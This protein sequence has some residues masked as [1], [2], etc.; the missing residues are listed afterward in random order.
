MVRLYE[1]IVALRPDWHDPD[2]AKGV[3]KVVM[4]GST[5][6]PAG[7][8]PHVYT[9]E[10]RKDL[11][12]RAKNPDDPL[13]LVIVRDMW[14]TGF[15]APSMHT[16]YLDKTMQGAG[17][18]QAIARVNRTFRDKPGGV[19]RR[20]H[21]GVLQSAEGAHRILADRPRSGGGA[22]RGH[23]GCAAGE[24]RHHHRAAAWLRLRLLPAPG[25]GRAAHP[26]RGRRGLR[27]E[28]PRPHRTVRRQVLALAKAY[29]LC[30]ARDEAVA[31][32]DD[33]R[34]FIDVR[35]AILKIQNPDAGRGGSGGV[36]IDTA[37]AQLVNEAVTADEVVDIYKLAG[38]ETPE[39]S[40][41]SDEFLDSLTDKEKPNLQMGPLRRLL[42]DEIKTVR[43]TNIVQARRFSEQLEEAINRYTNRSLT[44]AEVIAE[45]VKLAK[46]M[47]DDQKRHQ[48]LGLASTRSPSTT[49][50]CK[51]I[52][53]VLEMG[54][55]TLK[56]I[57][58]ELVERSVPA[59]PSTEPQR[60]RSGHNAD[61][62]P[63]AA[64]Q[65]RLPARPGG[66]WRSSWCCNKRSFSPAADRSKGGLFLAAGLPGVVALNAAA[67]R[68][69][70]DDPGHGFNYAM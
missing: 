45:L 34:L 49:P 47:R 12:L 61:Q 17:L 58:H 63:P 62:D 41:L 38:V 32:R 7:L 42:N 60:E 50:S 44:T 39:L 13:E 29:A 11:K 3:I 67:G 16:M 2:P 1:K 8:Q 40:I 46:E 43:R 18:M 22:D 35:S 51:T 24:A 33:V 55:A 52:A 69:C 20:L 70:C 36:E 66:Q 15:D 57:A 10:V 64:R 21:R 5:D 54:D 19:D 28:R 65:V 14:L 31:I 37:I 53:A 59:P 27:D 6:D 48:E 9:K 68:Q 25:P 56:K 30:G 23:R 4:T 26:A